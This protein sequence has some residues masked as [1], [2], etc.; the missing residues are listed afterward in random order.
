MNVTKAHSLA[1]DLMNLHGYGHVPFEFNRSV[2]SLG[3]TTFQGRPDVTGAH[4][5]LKVGLS[6]KF[7][8]ILPE[9]EIRDVIL[10]EIAHMIVGP[11]AGHGPVWKATARRIGA[12]PQRCASASAR[13]EGE[14][15][16]VC[17]KGHKGGTYHRHPQRLRFCIKCGGVRGGFGAVMTVYRNRVRVPISTAPVKFRAEYNKHLAKSL[18]RSA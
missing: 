5:I 10:H 14:F 7:V 8:E 18:T 1:R 15:T 13:P 9:D 2:T 16:L 4:R 17:D 11:K 6:R 12:K 3:K